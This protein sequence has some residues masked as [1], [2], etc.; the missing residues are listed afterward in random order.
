M[1]SSIKNRYH[2]YIRHNFLA[3]IDTDQVCRIVKR[4]QII[5]ILNGFHDLCI[6]HYTACKLLTA[7]YDTVSDCIDLCQRFYD[8]NLLV[9]QLF[10]HCRNCLCMCRHCD[11]SLYFLSAL[12][13]MCNTASVNSDSLTKSFCKHFFAFAVDELIFQ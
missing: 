13:L 11:L 10:D 6:D 8:A 4:C 9:C 12:R 7:M 1:E 2:R 5:T 3:G